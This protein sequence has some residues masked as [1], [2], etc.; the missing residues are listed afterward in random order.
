[1]SWIL[2]IGLALMS[3]VAMIFLFHLPR[4]VW[5][6][7]LAA[8]ML[9]LAGYAFQ[10]HPNERGY[11]S[12][13]RDIAPEDGWALVE[14]RKEVIGEAHQSANNHMLVADALMRKGQ[15]A[16]AAAV[17]ERLVQDNPNDVEGWVALGNAL[18][19]QA[20]GHLTPA[21]IVSFE[22]AQKVDPENLA[23]AFFIG[24]THLRQ[25]ELIEGR[26]TWAQALEKASEKT[27]WRNELQMRLDR[28]D[29]LLKRLADMP[30]GG[31]E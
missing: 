16:N 7:I 27:W 31:T 21:A 26:K 25:G 4:M 11:P 30:E 5:S 18:V 1:M 19:E 15:Y 8:L 24:A 2:A 10:G 3:F 6:A 20:E 17:L 12:P 14:A 28:L 29:E 9:G 13:Y 23:P 22:H